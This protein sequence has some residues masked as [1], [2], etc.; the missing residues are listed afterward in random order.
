VKQLSPQQRQL[1]TSLSNRLA[2]IP[3]IRAVVLA[4]SHAR[5]QAHA[6]SDI[7]LGILY[8]DATPFFIDTVRDLAE[9]VN[10]IPGPVVTSFYEWGPWVNGG[11]WLT[12]GGQRVDFIYRSLEHV[13]RVIADAEAGRYELDYAQQPPFG[14][15]GPTYLG[16]VSVCIPLFDP[17]GQVEWLKRRVEDY[18]DAL[19]R[20][21]VQDYLWA[22]EFGVAAFA[23]KYAAR[24]DAYGTG[25]CLGRAIN[26]LVLVLFALNRRYLIND[27]T[28]LAEVAE[29]ERAPR[30]FRARVQETLG[31]LGK[32]AAELKAAVESIGQLVREVVEL[33]E[34]QYQRRFRLPQ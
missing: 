25:A 30:E 29:F 11:A 16:E 24:G 21:V 34:G 31:Q 1:V 9:D 26:Q 10:D 2:V 4:G 18:P 32:T 5:G 17:G 20:A 27:K 8:S 14:F 3:G 19:R 7:D 15:F 28:G 22:A 23:S 33:A 6:T 13:Q 12:V